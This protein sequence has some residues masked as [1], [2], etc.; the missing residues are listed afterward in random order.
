MIIYISLL[1]GTGKS[2][3]G[4]YLDKRAIDFGIHTKYYRIA[5]LLELQDSMVVIQ[6]H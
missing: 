6:K 3:L 1:C 4:Q 2:F 5:T